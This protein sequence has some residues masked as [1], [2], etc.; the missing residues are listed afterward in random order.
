MGFEK[1]AQRNIE[2]LLD[3]LIADNSAPRLDCTS[4]HNSEL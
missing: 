3:D 4:D 1:A 2:E